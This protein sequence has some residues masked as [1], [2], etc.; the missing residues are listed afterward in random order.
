MTTKKWELED[1]DTA[2]LQVYS[3]ASPIVDNNNKA[4]LWRILASATDKGSLVQIPVGAPGIL[5]DFP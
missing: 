3:R 2:R 1:K 5:T 4:S